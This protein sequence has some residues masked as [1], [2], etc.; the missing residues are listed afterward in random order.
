M[1]QSIVF[2][3]VDFPADRAMMRIEQETMDPAFTYIGIVARRANPNIRALTTKFVKTQQEK[4]P[5]TP[6]AAKKQTND[7]S[8]NLE[9]IIEAIVET[10]LAERVVAQG[11]RVVQAPETT[12]PVH[13]P[14]YA[15]AVKAGADVRARIISGPGMVSSS[16]L[17][18][19]MGVSRETVNQKRQ[20]GSLLALTHGTRLQRYPTWQLEPKVGEAMPDLLETLQTLDPWTQY[21][22]ITQGIPAL[23][24]T[25][26]LD[27]LRAGE[28]DRVMAVAAEYA[29]LMAPA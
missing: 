18:K 26:P 4:A 11:S 22:F 21:L 17:A 16:E 15:A 5:T 1:G 13:T 12:T 14:G 10:K 9:Q 7:L 19:L 25:S 29:D 23:D 3:H 20:K 8:M 2:G 24:G 6:R 27:A 28:R